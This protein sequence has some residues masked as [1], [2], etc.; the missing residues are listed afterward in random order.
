[1]AL[2]GSFVPAS[3]R[4]YWRDSDGERTEDVG[5]AMARAAR[6]IRTDIVFEGEGGARLAGR[7]RARS[8]GSYRPEIG[9][10]PGKTEALQRLR[11]PASAPAVAPSTLGKTR[12]CAG[13]SAFARARPP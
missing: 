9:G 4:A 5:A 7:T 10:L 1:M 8:G 12:V 13:S 6:A 2:P 11:P 3:V